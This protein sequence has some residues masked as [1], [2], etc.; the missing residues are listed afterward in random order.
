MKY[1]MYINA[2]SCILLLLLRV[3][4]V[5]YTRKAQSIDSRQPVKIVIPSQTKERATFRFLLDVCFQCCNGGPIDPYI[6]DKK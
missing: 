6:R 5:Y 1:F 4:S 3:L 2:W